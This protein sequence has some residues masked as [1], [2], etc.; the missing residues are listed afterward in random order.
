MASLD[1]AF[2]PLIGNNNN[3]NNNNNNKQINAQKKIST[4]CPSCKNSNS[5]SLKRL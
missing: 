5:I 4:L 3:N 1:I 2:L